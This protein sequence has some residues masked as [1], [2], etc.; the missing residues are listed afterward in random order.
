[1]QAR[2]AVYLPSEPFLRYPFFV[3]PYVKVSEIVAAFIVFFLPRK[4][5]MLDMPA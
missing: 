4:T 1:M 2:K 3:Q 5:S